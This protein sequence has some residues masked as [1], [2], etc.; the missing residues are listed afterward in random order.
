MPF[1]V[2]LTRAKVDGHHRYF[3]VYDLY[4]DQAGVFWFGL[5]DGE[6]VR[7]DVQTTLQ[8]TVVP[9][10]WQKPWFVV[11]MVVFI[12]AVSVQTARV[13]RRDRR[14]QEANAALSDANKDLFGVNQELKEKTGDLEESNQELTLEAALD[15]VRGMALGMQES[16][17]LSPLVVVVAGWWSLVVVLVVVGRR[18]AGGRGGRGGRRGAGATAVVGCWSHWLGQTAGV[19]CCW[20]SLLEHPLSLLEP[21]A[22]ADCWGR[23]LGPLLSLAGPLDGADRRG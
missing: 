11:M 21:P 1:N 18:G 16:M 15:R 22:G 17:A 6:V 5:W 4:E 14:L 7:Y 19:S 10:V 23:L 2:T 3:P 9:P 12:G 20:G 8:V 13:V